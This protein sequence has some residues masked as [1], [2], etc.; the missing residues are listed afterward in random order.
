MAA[1]VPRR[2]CVGCGRIAPK[3]ELLRIAAVTTEASRAHAVADPLARMSGRGAYL[4]RAGE[5]ARPKESCL[6][7]AERRGA[8]ARALRRALPGGLVLN[9]SKLVE[10]V[11]R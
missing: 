9:D 2:R 3:S 8:I 5:A 1:H 6:A 11:S 4:C 7:P 10:S